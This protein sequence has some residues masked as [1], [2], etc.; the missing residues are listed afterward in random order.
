MGMVHVRLII[1]AAALAL[2]TPGISQALPMDFG[3]WAPGPW[4]CEIENALAA[5]PRLAA[6]QAEFLSLC[7][8]DA[9]CWHLKRYRPGTSELAELRHHGS[10]GR[11]LACAPFE[12][13]SPVL[14]GY[15]KRFVVDFHDAA[16]LYEV[17]EDA[18][19]GQI[20]AENSLN[21]TLDDRIQNLLASR[22]D[23]SVAVGSIG[24]GQIHVARARSVERMAALIEGRAVRSDAEIARQLLTERGSI[25]YAAA[26]LRDAWKTYERVAGVDIR[27]NIPVLA[28]LYN[29]GRVAER[30]EAV[31]RTGREPQENYMG[32]F[33]RHV[34]PFVA[35][36]R[37]YPP[38]C[39]P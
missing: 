32:F 34:L 39:E 1:T 24:F 13:V 29:L 4:T 27:E 16:E 11:R 35:E 21:V 12:E 36:I 20:L 28:T 6:K 22:S 2:L 9:E 31:H 8:R 5:D 3:G 30:A 38:T 7:A 37:L 23:G 14:V 10:A 18:L 25:Y 26:I 19:I 17:S 33:V 15:L